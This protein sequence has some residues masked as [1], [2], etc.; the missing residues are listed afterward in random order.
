MIC[1]FGKRD[2]DLSTEDVIDW[3]IFY[4]EEFIRVNGTD[5]VQDISFKSDSFTFRN[6]PEDKIQV[7][8]Y[9]RWQDEGYVP[10]MIAQSTLDN[11]NNIKLFTHL[12]GELN[13]LSNFLF[14]RLNNK[15]WLSHP[16][17]LTKTKI[18]VMKKAV[19]CGLLVPQTLITS[20]KSDLIDFKSQYKR[21]ISKPIRDVQGFFTSNS[22][23][24]TKTI[25]ITDDLISELPE[26]FFPSQ[27]Q[28]LIVKD[29]ELRIF[30]LNG[31]FY[32]MAIFSQLDKQTEIDFRVYNWVKPNRQVPY[33]LK[34]TIREKLQ[35]LMDS[36]KMTT[37]S[38]DMIRARNGDFIFLE[39]NPVGQFGMTSIPC[40][41]F[42]EKKIAEH[43]IKMK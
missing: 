28:E 38:I 34:D 10:N 17:E 21:I 19:E 35:L 13:V 15:R 2:I 6:I 12:K 41:Y 7:C 36:L 22:F 43:L 20:N 26:R 24:T 31:E 30:Y 40:N 1:I 11:D 5:F 27:F 33:K 14:S 32:P 42:L 29:Y 8:W 25:E 39:I 4:N 16:N 9:R 23:I 18:S 37:G 3:L